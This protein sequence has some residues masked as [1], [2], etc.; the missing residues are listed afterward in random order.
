MSVKDSLEVLVP[1]VVP[2]NLVESKP[3]FVPE[4][5]QVPLSPL[6]MVRE[7]GTHFLRNLFPFFFPGPAAVRPHPEAGHA[8]EESDQE[9]VV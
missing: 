2:P 6:V 8:E 5:E 4:I 9:H 1:V 7:P 3:T